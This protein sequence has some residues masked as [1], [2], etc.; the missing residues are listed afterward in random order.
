MTALFESNAAATLT[1]VSEIY[2]QR[3]NEYADTWRNCRWLAVLATARKLG[4][5]LSP[6]QCRVI[7]AAAM[8]DIKYARL[9][10]GFKDDTVIDGIAYAANWAEEMKN[11][12]AVKGGPSRAS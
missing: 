9:E 10:G 2:A 12:S 3:G 4:V 6:D 5:N 8:V 7:A 11:F 1:R